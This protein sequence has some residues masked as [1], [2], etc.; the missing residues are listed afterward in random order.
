MVKKIAFIGAGSITE[1]MILGILK[2][3]YLTSEQIFV[4]NKENDQRRKEL[5]EK[6]NVHCTK[7][8]KTLLTNADII[9][10]TVKPT[11]LELVIDSFKEY[12]RPEQLVI[13]VLA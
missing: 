3:E 2:N 12:I 10:F 7:D 1:A 4:T 9:L 13:S 11:D 8:P 5:S 6:F